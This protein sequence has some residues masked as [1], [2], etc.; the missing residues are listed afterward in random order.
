MIGT[1]LEALSHGFR[2]GY[3]DYDRLAAQLEAWARAFP[4][5]ARVEVIGH[6]DQ[7]RDLRVLTLGP[8]PDRARPAV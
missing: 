6:T 7:G 5:L 4:D 3:L 2:D 1:P 8:E